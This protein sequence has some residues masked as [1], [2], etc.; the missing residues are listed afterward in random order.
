MPVAD[1]DT[2]RRSA[3]RLMLILYRLRNRIDS[4]WRR[5]PRAQGDTLRTLRHADVPIQSLQIRR[6]LLDRL[7]Q[8]RPVGQ[9]SLADALVARDEAARRHAVNIQAV[10]R[11]RQAR[12]AAQAECARLADQ[13]EAAIERTA[14]RLDAHIREGDSGPLPQ[15]TPTDRHVLAQMIADRTLKAA[16]RAVTSL[17]ADAER[18]A[19]ELSRTECAL[20][21]V[22]G[23]AVVARVRELLSELEQIR[24]RETEIV[25]LVAVIRTGDYGAVSLPREASAAVNYPPARPTAD[26]IIGG[27]IDI[28]TPIGGSPELNERARAYWREY[29]EQL[30]G[31]SSTSAPAEAA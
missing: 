16:E 6:P 23:A 1:I 27:A 17:E 15:V 10:E 24:T 30:E 7:E 29:L 18:S 9:L 19:E 12:A 11:A 26:G 8:L 28:N 3:R 21:L 14:R 5:Q 20:G 4:G 13:D 25:R 22:R 2:L 31:E